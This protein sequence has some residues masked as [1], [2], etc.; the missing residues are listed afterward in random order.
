M[1]Q[2][3]NDALV[4]AYELLAKVVPGDADS[5]DR[6]NAALDLVGQLLAGN[7]SPPFEVF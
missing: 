4:A 2:E 5:I 1:T 6:L 7:L 3:E